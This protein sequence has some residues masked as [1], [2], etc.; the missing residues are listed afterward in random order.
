MGKSYFYAFWTPYKK[1]YPDEKTKGWT[2]FK[3][4]VELASKNALGGAGR[5]SVEKA[6]KYGYLNIP[7][8]KIG[9]DLKMSKEKS[10]ELNDGGFIWFPKMFMRE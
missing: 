10:M 5:N 7:L 4:P 2:V 9:N 6:S 3:C 8:T 1:A